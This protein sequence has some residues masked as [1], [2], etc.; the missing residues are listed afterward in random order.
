MRS[1]SLAFGPLLDPGSDDT[2]SGGLH[3][4]L[5]ASCLHL[6]LPQPQIPTNYNFD[7]PL[8]KID[9]IMILPFCFLI[10][11][12]ISEKINGILCLKAQCINI[13]Q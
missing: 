1:F 13:K 8:N 10:S 11:S 2:N 9:P 12:G 6:A 7:P 4:L 3:H 5:P